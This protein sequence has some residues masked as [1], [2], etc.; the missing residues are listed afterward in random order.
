M[1]KNLAVGSKKSS[2]RDNKA[3]TKS[4]LPPPKMFQHGVKWEQKRIIALL[5]AAENHIDADR[6]WYAGLAHAIALIKGENNE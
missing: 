5:E 2:P 1:G 6:D 4:L 3:V